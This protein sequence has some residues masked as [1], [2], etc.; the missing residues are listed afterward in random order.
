MGIHNPW[1]KEELA[2]IEEKNEY[3]LRFNF[4]TFVIPKRLIKTTALKKDNLLDYITYINWMDLMFGQGNSKVDALVNLLEAILIFAK[5]H[6][7]TNF[8]DVQRFKLGRTI[9]W[10]NSDIN[11]ITKPWNS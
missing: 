6:N 8:R 3:I 11:N 1:K 4:N 9:I 5:K 2:F 7:L 10:I